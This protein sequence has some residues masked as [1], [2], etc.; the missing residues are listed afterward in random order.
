MSKRSVGYETSRLEASGKWV[1]S[2][3]DFKLQSK[4]KIREYE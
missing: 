1:M 3:Q 4:S 2:L